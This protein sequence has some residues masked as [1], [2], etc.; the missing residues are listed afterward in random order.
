MASTRERILETAERLFLERGFHATTMQDVADRLDITKPA[1]YYHFSSK[2]EILGSLLDP[3]TNELERVLNEAIEAHGER[4]DAVQVA[5]I[6]GWLDVFLRSKGTLL[7][8]FRELATVST[9]TFG[10]LLGVM[11][12]AIVVAV[13]PDGGV[14]ERIAFAQAI[15]A[16]TDPVAFLSD[17]PDPVLR[18]HLLVGVWR[19]L[20]ISPDAEP[21]RASGPGRPRALSGNEV[22]RVHELYETGDYTAG[23]I[24]ERTGVSRA[25]VYRYLK[26][27]RNHDL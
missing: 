4:T 26:K 19:L 10:R 8:M 3:L 5:L 22:A 23:E 14:P 18:K 1:L 27:S 7:A 17:I 25:T 13:G 2:A 11:E 12:Q 24:A 9:D 21:S 6:S 16:I 20:G 15:S